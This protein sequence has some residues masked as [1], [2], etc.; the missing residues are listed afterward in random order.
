MKKISSKT[1]KVIMFSG[2]GVLCVGVLCAVLFLANTGSSAAAAADTSGETTVSAVSGTVT[3]PSV[4]SGTPIDGVVSNDDG[5]A[6]VPQKGKS[7]SKPLNN[8]SNPASQPPKPAV[9]GD[10]KNGSQPTNPA[11]TDKTKKPSYVTPPK[12]P[13]QTSGK[14]NGS[15]S[16]TNNG[17]GSSNKSGGG[18]KGDPVLD[19]A[20]KEQG[21]NQQTTAN[22]MY[23]DGTK[24][25]TMD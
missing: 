6:F 13:T 20:I 2:M 7:E 18:T 17:G 24:V 9:Q 4:S 15:G 22:D 23:E 5:A 3:V 25:G 19:K 21:G 11:L 14:S 16:G 12:A 10:S 8:F 1:K